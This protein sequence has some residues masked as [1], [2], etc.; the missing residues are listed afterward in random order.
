M[1]W[2]LIVPHSTLSN[3][4][5]L[6]GVTAHCEG[7][8]MLSH[9]IVFQRWGHVWTSTIVILEHIF[10]NVLHNMVD[11]NTKN[12]ITKKIHFSNLY[13]EV[14]TYI[15]G[16]KNV[17]HYVFKNANI[18]KIWLKWCLVFMKFLVPIKHCDSILL[19]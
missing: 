7:P 3:I 19:E 11:Y 14:P 16:K 6:W 13:C 2:H 1:W 15:C 4:S 10:S 12:S 9:Y 8:K 17:R 18:L 5:F